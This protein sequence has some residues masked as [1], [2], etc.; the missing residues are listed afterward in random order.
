MQGLWGRG[1]CEFT[2][3]SVS[4][5]LLS[6]ALSPGAVS[7]LACHAGAGGAGRQGGQQAMWAIKP[8]AGRTA[9]TRNRVAAAGSSAI[10]L[11]VCA[12]IGA[13]GGT[14]AAASGAGALGQR[15]VAGERPASASHPA[16]GADARWRPA[17]ASLSK[18]RHVWI[19]EL[20]NVGYGK[21]FGDPSRDPELA[22]VLAGKGALLKRYYGIGHDSLDNYIAEMSGQAPDFQTGQDCEIYSSFLQFSG[23]TFDKWTRDRQLSGDGCVYPAY[24]PTIASQLTAHHLT[25]KSYNQ[26]MGNDPKRDGTTATPHGP[27]C[28]HPKLGSVDKTDVTGPANDSYAT[29]HNPFVYFKGIIDNKTY[30]DDHVV[31]LAPLRHD[32]RSATTTPN[33]SFITPNTCFDGHD[34]PRCQNGRKGGLARSMSSWPSGCRGSWHRPPTGMA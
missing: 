1:W 18:I 16:A 33:Y 2:A 5:R 20:E 30:C 28:G 13:F 19:I 21:S 22:K 8:G 3:G 24:V 34:T 26:D 25:W 29:R 7:I 6:A 15:S 27:A 23:E 31:T 10:A 32:L 4:V 11:A 12:L 17:T 9:R 14:A